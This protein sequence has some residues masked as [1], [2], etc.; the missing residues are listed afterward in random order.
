[1]IRQRWASG[2]RNNEHEECLGCIYSGKHFQIIS[3]RKKKRIRDYYFQSEIFLLPSNCPKY[4][5]DYLLVAEM[6]GLAPEVKRVHQNDAM[7]I[8]PT[9]HRQPLQKFRSVQI[10]ESL[11]YE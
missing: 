11:D 2:E 8:E 1:M 7:L 10:S 5:D 4:Q 3:M 6:E 9:Q